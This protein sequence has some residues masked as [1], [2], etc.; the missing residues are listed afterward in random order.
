MVDYAQT[1]TNDIQLFAA[2][3]T[4]KWNSIVWGTD[5]WG[6]GSDVVT[7]THHYLDDTQDLTL[8]SEVIAAFTTTISF[9]SLSMD[10]DLDGQ[11]LVDSAGF[12]HVFVGNTTEGEDRVLTDYTEVDGTTASWSAVSHPSTS[13]S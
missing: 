8:T 4:N 9:G 11:T 1:I 12:Y 3:P 5:N 13:W 10:T 2:E 7:D 6:Y